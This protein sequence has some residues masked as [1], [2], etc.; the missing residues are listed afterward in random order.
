MNKQELFTKVATHLL[1]QNK[2]AAGEDGCMMHAPDGTKCA[3]GCLL[4]ESAM[5]RK[6][7]YLGAR[8]LDNGMGP[9]AALLKR[10][11]SA[12]GVAKG[13]Y[14]LLHSLQNI[15]DNYEPVDWPPMLRR[16]SDKFE[17]DKHT[18]N[19]LI[20]KYN[21]PWLRDGVY[22]WPMILDSLE[23]NK[24]DEIHFKEIDDA[25]SEWPTCACGNLCKGLPRKEDGTPVD[26]ILFRRG[27]RFSESIHEVM[28]GDDIE[29]QL[30]AAREAL[31]GIEERTAELLEER[32]IRREVA[33]ESIGPDAWEDDTWLSIADDI[34]DAVE[35]NAPCYLGAIL[36]DRARSYMEEHAK[37]Q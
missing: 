7:Q 36:M 16:I 35:S 5:S 13:D 29:Y 28:N 37:K 3:I 26:Q 22:D 25:A 12:V 32:R 31:N 18:I 6:I 34:A 20:A 4:P 15:H 9:R 24:I 8:Y 21:K 30:V 27:V 33:W 2:R 11:L 10:I 23:D 19:Q 14:L 1:K 17:L